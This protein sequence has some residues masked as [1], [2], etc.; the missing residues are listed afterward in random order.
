MET[1]LAGFY[2]SLRDTN[3]E[4]YEVVDR[5]RT[6]ILDQD[7]HIT[8]SLHADRVIFTVNDAYSVF[9]RPEEQYV[10]VGIMG[11][12]SIPEGDGFGRTGQHPRIVKV[13][14]REDVE[15]PEFRTF[16]ENAIQ[17]SNRKRQ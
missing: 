14:A 5:V 15:S 16:I 9:V 6:L 2:E 7:P 4:F 8:E 3:R 17:I 11:L 12:K 10:V 1:E 13:S